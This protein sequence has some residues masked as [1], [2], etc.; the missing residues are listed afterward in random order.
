[1]NLSQPN[2]NPKQMYINLNPYHETMS[3]SLPMSLN[4]PQ[5]QPQ[6]QMQIDCNTIKLNIENNFQ[7]FPQLFSNHLFCKLQLNEEI[8]RLNNNSDGEIKNIKMKIDHTRTIIEDKKQEKNV[9]NNMVKMVFD[10]LN[11]FGIIVKELSDKLLYRYQVVVNDLTLDQNNNNK[12]I[13]AFKEYLS[14]FESIKLKI[15]ENLKFITNDYNSNLALEKGRVNE[16]KNYFNER[17]DKINKEIINIFQDVDCNSEFKKVEE[18][19]VKVQ[20]V[21][22]LVE[23]FPQGAKKS[24]QPEKINFVK[25][26]EEEEVV[27]EEKNIL[28]HPKESDNNILLNKNTNSS[29]DLLKL[30]GYNKRKFKS[31]LNN[32]F[33]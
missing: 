10:K 19:L 2:F 7:K 11:K 27:N 16:I 9:T 6:P 33:Y 3:E 26:K 13:T 5:P 18:I 17:I 8:N 1:M 14:Q 32:L 24:I 31:K 28:F 22:K 23:S 29:T 20:E 12:A 25:K 21:K 4:L 30:G 15:N